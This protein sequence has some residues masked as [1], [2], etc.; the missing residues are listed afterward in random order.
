MNLPIIS[1]KK[2]ITY[3]IPMKIFYYFHIYYKIKMYRNIRSRQ[4]PVH[5]QTARK[6]L[7]IKIEN[8]SI[9]NLI[10]VLYG[11]ILTYARGH[12]GNTLI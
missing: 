2:K 4:K 9:S 6:S 11:N 7:L 3:F 5:A 1:F 12:S 8:H 10:D